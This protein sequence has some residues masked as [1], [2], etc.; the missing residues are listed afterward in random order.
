MQTP[1]WPSMAGD[2]KLFGAIKTKTQT[3]AAGAHNAIHQV[4]QEK[5][6][7]DLRYRASNW[8]TA[9]CT[10]AHAVESKEFEVTM[11]ILIVL[12]C[13]LVVLDTNNRAEHNESPAWIRM[14]MFCMLWIYVFE[15]A[16]RLWAFRWRYF[17]SA[18]NVF[19][20]TVVSLDVFAEIL[21]FANVEI[22]L[23]LSA[24]R[25]LRL[26]RL[27]R[28]LR[29]VHFFHELYVMCHLMVAACRTIFWAAC[30][31]IVMLILW[32]IL[33]VELLH[34]L[35]TEIA[36]TTTAYDDCERC[37][38]AFSSVQQSC[39]TFFQQIIAGDSWGQVSL[40]II[41]N[42]PAAGVFAFLVLVTMNLGLMNL[43]VTVIV[44]KAQ[45]AREENLA[46]QAES[47][48][49]AWARTKETLLALCMS[50]DADKS[51]EISLEELIKG[52]EVEGSFADTMDKMGI[53]K[54]DISTL[55][56]VLDE[57]GS[58]NV[59]YAE[60]IDHLWKMKTQSTHSVCIMIKAYVHQLG[61]ALH[62]D[63]RELHSEMR[64]GLT[65]LGET[66]RASQ[67]KTDVEL[68]LFRNL[69]SESCPPKCSEPTIESKITEKKSLVPTMVFSGPHTSDTERVEVYTRLQEQ[70]DRQLALETRNSQLLAS[71]AES[72]KLAASAT[73][74]AAT[75]ANEPS[76]WSS[77]GLR[78]DL[79]TIDCSPWSARTDDMP[80]PGTGPIAASESHPQ[81]VQTSFAPPRSS[82]ASVGHGLGEPQPIFV[83]VRDA[84]ARSRGSNS[85]VDRPTP[86]GVSR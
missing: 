56:E 24:L 58:G 83:A 84:N 79:P 15:L 62:N 27:L 9:R 38:R 43:V 76:A 14:P 85:R 46:S 65:Q 74:P 67:T 35:N 68:N 22:N 55:F 36:E 51:G 26:G 10:V 17:R 1:P 11:A 3:F 39:L 48:E 18:M 63:I 30:L 23:P 86:D 64:T 52:F 72:T 47:V 4:E 5:F 32:G 73:A 54:L 8:S 12:N 71:I 40:V 66:V 70:V 13:V 28:F 78:C 41:E 16:I 2:A 45:E 81:F 33:A 61:N 25:I 69:L 60:F 6:S 20:L 80:I 29:T 19:D 7:E 82:A 77:S 75:H 31:L 50:I 49:Q 42:Y 44:D 34:P 37:P 53:E 57:D 21:G 59:S